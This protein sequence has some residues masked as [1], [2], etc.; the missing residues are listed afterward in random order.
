MALLKLSVAILRI[1]ELVETK[2]RNVWW[3]WVECYKL[4]HIKS[5]REYGLT[6]VIAS[7]ELKLFAISR[8]ADY[9][10]YGIIAYGKLP[11]MLTVNCPIKQAVGCENVKASLPT[12][13]TVNLR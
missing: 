10:P 1:S 2:I 4:I 7:F 11:V 6:D 9:L 13:Q 5:S 3:L 8:L 12:G